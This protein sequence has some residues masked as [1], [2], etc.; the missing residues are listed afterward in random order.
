ME[1]GN[2]RA[3]EAL[4]KIQVKSLGPAVVDHEEE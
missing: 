1:D 2:R 4:E 3:V